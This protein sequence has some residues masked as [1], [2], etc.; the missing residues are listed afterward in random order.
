MKYAIGYLRVSTPDQKKYGNSLSTQK[1]NIEDFCFKNN[2]TLLKIFTEDFS[3]AD[4][5]R[6]EFLKLLNYLKQNKGEIDLLLIDRQD[7]FSRNTEHALTMTR[8][9]K[10]VGVE[11]NFVSEWIENVNSQEGKLI[12][13]IRYTLAELER[14][15]IKKICS[16]GSRTALKEGRYT[17][18]PPRGFKR[19]KNQFN[20]TIIEPNEVA[21]LV[22]ELFVDYAFN[23]YSQKE[24]LSKYR[25]KGMSLSKS[26]LS[27]MLTN[28]LYAGFIDLKKHDIEP[29]NLIKGEHKAIISLELYQK[30]Q[31]VKDNRNTKLKNTKIENENFP[32]SGFLK[33]P[34]CGENLTGSNSNNG[35]KKKIKKYYFY[36]ECK[37]K[38]GCKIRYTANDVHD[39]LDKELS[40][41]RPNKYIQKL[42]IDLLIEEYENFNYERLTILKQ[43]DSRILKINE[44]RFSL[45]EKF[46]ANLIEEDYFKEI[47]R[48]YVVNKSRLEREK[49]E[50]GTYQKDLDKLLTFGLNMICN[51]NL[52]FKNSTNQLK[53][54]L[55]GSIL[56]DGLIFSNNNFR[57]VNYNRAVSL[58]SKLDKG[59][60]QFENKKGDNYKIVSQ[61]V[62][63]VGIEPTHPKVL[64]FESSSKWFNMYLFVLF[65]KQL[66]LF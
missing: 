55:L 5:D 64:D 12:S 49:N 47:N 52:L 54:R 37:S 53:K 65:F 40:K 43:I 18:T 22:K 50:L 46:V 44:L 4:F 2:I 61:S 8:K 25:K 9:L 27:R 59:Y 10:K 24:L 60:K 29:Y 28:I 51:F 31:R 15:K 62:L 34:C 21:N 45:T 48:K 7:R 41:L 19:S 56:E 17:K 42:F 26:S 63:K 30:V 1:N 33:C 11:V 23:I 35:N 16:M 58:I 3:G 13:N 36:Y 32:L 14:D 6:P 57:T 20:K 39:L 66:P 38:K